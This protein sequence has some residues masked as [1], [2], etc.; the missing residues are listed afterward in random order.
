MSYDQHLGEIAKIYENSTPQLEEEINI[1]KILNLEYDEVRLHSRI[2]KFLIERDPSGFIEST[3]KQYWDE[4]DKPVGRLLNVDLEKHC[5][6]SEEDIKDGRIDLI[7]EFEQHLIIIENKIL[8]SDQPDQLIKYSKFGKKSGKEFLLLYL[9]PD[10]KLPGEISISNNGKKDLEE[11]ND[12]FTISYEKNIL[13]WLEHF[14]NSK[15]KTGIKN[16]IDQY[17]NTIKTI[18]GIMTEDEKKR[19]TAL[20]SI[21]ANNQ[22]NE[23]ENSFEKLSKIKSDIERIENKIHEF[24]KKV[25]EKLSEELSEEPFVEK[26]IKQSSC[27]IMFDICKKGR[28]QYNL[29]LDYKLNLAAPSF[30]FWVDKTH[31]NNLNFK[32]ELKNDE[33]EINPLGFLEKTE[34]KDDLNGLFN[35]GDLIKFIGSNKEEET[36]EWE[37]SKISEIVSR[38]KEIFEKNRKLIDILKKNL[39]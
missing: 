32:D 27:S 31:H 18:C 26:D 4:I 6:S 29:Y 36:N 33:Y 14:E 1:F 13:N 10:G 16:I 21:L 35:Q 9:T 7:V 17:L 11:N 28:G 8:G 25:S 39:E 23:Q 19:I 38:L 34:S 3:P 37:E 20:L 2:L 12:F 30:G 15:E 5:S 24:W 22:I